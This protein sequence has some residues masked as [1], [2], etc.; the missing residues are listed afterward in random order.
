[1]SGSPLSGDT[2][3]TL[4]IDLEAL[5][6]NW[7]RLRDLA[8]P[9]ECAAVVKADAYGIGLAEAGRA[10][11]EAGCRTFFVAHLAEG[12][13]LRAAAPDSTIYILNGLPP[14]A[15]R[16]FLEEDL[17]PIL[18]SGDEV[19]EWA[20]F[21]AGNGR[22]LPAAWHVDTGMN[23]L[24]LGAGEAE[25]LAGEAGLPRPALLM[26]H[27][28]TAERPDDPTNARQVERFA[29]LC[30]AFPGVP[31]SLANSSGIFLPS[32]PHHDLVR[33]GY[34]LY[35]GNPT[36]GRANPMQPVVR[37]EAGII[38]TRQVSP[39]ERAGYN[40]RWTAR[41]ARRLATLSLGYADGYLRSASTTDH[42]QAEHRPTGAALVAGRLC[43][44]VGSIS[45]DLT[46]LDVTDAPRAERGDLAVLI[47]DELTVD[48]V[49][50]RAG[51]I[52][53]EVLTSLGR[54]YA[55]RYIGGR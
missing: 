41:G 17:R 29:R 22:D 28:V 20:A 10:L 34:A 19:R 25:A 2:A 1:V 8:E 37:L 23:R 51:T 12:A 48:E 31:A 46:I 30:A 24:G 33:P 18:G 45:M 42:S 27:L 15:G 26:S 55:R 47:G 11:A 39:G 9:A 49:G 38:Q 6:A 44:V 50:R 54:R 40:G 35:G 13:R 5:A 53:Y 14:G 36:P 21:A 7:R 16:R 4:T 43:P 3:A 32:R 52:G